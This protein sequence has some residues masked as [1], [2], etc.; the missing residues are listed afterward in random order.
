MK[1]TKYTLSIETETLH[2]DSIPALL[3]KIIEEMYNEVHCG[4]LQF[5]DG[6]KVKWSIN[7]NNVEF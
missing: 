5:D 4:K 3:Q 1:A 7:S 6:D 2:T